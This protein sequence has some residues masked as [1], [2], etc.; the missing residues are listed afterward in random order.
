MYS[1]SYAVIH[2]FSL[3]VHNNKGHFSSRASRA[4]T[5]ILLIYSKSMLHNTTSHAFLEM[6]KINCPPDSEGFLPEILN[7]YKYNEFTTEANNKTK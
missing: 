4:F 3:A 6:L 2:I 7:R 5:V 1:Q